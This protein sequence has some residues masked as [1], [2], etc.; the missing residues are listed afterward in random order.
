MCQD[1]NQD[2]IIF[3][4]MRYLLSSF[5]STTSS[6]ISMTDQSVLR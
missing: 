5:D 1:S 2:V 6:H 3:R 4:R